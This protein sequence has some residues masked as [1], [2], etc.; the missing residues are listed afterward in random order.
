MASE[1]RVNKIT[2]TAGVGT[3][4]TSADGIVVSGILTANNFSGSGANLTSIPAGQL[5]G[6]LPAISGANLTSLPSQVTIANNANDRV[7]TG[8]SGTNLNGE[9][10]LTFN[11]STMNLTAGSGDA[12]LT[13]IGTEGNDARISLVADDGDDHIDQWNIRSKASNN[14]LTIDQFGGGTFNTRLTIAS[15]AN[16]GNVTVN[17]GNLIIGTSG[18]GVDFSATPNGYSGTLQEI[19]DDY[20]EGYWTPTVGGWSASGTGVYGDQK[21][22][23]TKIGNTVTVFF[24]VYW[25]GLNNASGVFAIESLP[26]PHASNQYYFSTAVQMRYVDY[27]GDTVFAIGGHDYSSSLLFYAQ[28]DNGNHNYVAVDTNGGRIEGCVT[29]LTDS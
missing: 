16:N 27:S 8:G 2:H 19:L 28:N 4:T 13:L 25:T 21:G 6:T 29:Y 3:I 14:N 11:G 7:I 24:H 9:S 23:Y 17:T 5:T 22:R 15:D 12:R 1:I 20:E 26:F 18:K 10:G